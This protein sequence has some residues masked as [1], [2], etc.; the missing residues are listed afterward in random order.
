MSA[1]WAAGSLSKQAVENCC[2]RALSVMVVVIG[3]SGE[4]GPCRRPYSLTSNEVFL[5][6]GFSGV[7]GGQRRVCLA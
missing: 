2:H 3:A 1:P 7:R 6:F 4:A 5:L